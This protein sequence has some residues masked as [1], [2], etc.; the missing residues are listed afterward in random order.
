M[1]TLAF[2]NSPFISPPNSITLH[3][4]MVVVKAMGKPN[5]T[6]SPAS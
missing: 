3:E 2:C 6:L 1:A 4:S 5:L